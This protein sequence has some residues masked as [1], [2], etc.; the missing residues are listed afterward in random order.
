MAKNGKGKDKKSPNQ[1]AS[2]RAAT[3][4]AREII[5][6]WPEAGEDPTQRMNVPTEL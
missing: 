3:N 4:R 6:S 1:R 2:Y 5:P